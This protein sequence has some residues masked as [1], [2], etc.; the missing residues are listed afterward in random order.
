MVKDSLHLVFRYSLDKGH[1]KRSEAKVLN[2]YFVTNIDC[3]KYVY[4]LLTYESLYI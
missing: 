1:K 4:I 2:K 3:S